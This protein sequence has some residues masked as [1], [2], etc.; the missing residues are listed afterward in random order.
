MQQLKI[1]LVQL[2]SNGDCLYATAVARQIK[3]DYPDSHLTWA[4]ADFCKQ[5]IVGNPYVDDTLVVHSVPKNDVIGFRR[6]RKLVYE[7]KRKGVWDKIVITNLIDN[8]QANYDGCIRSAI[9]RGYERK[10]VVPVLPVLKLSEKE[11]QNAATFAIKNNLSLYKQ[12]IL[13]EFAPQ[14]GQSKIDFDFAMHVAEELTKANEIAIILSSANKIK[15]TSPRII[16]GSTLTLRETA[17]ITHYCTFLLG[18]SSGITW[19][20]TSSAAKQLPMVQL[21]NPDTRWVNPISR[22]FERFGISTDSLIELIEFD[23]EKL[24]LVLKAAFNNFEAARRIYHQAIPLHF[25]TTRNI[26]YNLLCYLQFGS[27]WKH[28]KVNREQYGHNLGFYKE[29][30]LALLLF[31]FRLIAN[32]IRKRL[33]KTVL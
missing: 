15:S 17:A 24:M 20:S 32:V 30:L 27:V 21:L 2:Y 16:D 23:R 22:D 8:R 29:V 14:S 13:F 26:I 25:K 6:F 18:C 3:Q 12:V 11:N 19:I 9:F 4:I 33:L 28:V 1:L 31:P 10:I 5:I 7:Q